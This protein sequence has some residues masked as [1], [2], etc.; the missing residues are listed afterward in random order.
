MKIGG[1]RLAKNSK[2]VLSAFIAN[3]K[4]SIPNCG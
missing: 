2:P 1:T 3:Y 4:T